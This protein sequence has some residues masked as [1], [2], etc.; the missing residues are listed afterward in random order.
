MILFEDI[1]FNLHCNVSKASTSFFKSLSFY[2]WLFR[3]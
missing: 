2:L 1:T 3:A